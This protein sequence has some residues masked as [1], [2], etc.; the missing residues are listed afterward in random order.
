ME[1]EDSRADD[2]LKETDDIIMK[3]MEEVK[4]GN[5]KET[6]GEPMPSKNGEEKEWDRLWALQLCLHDHIGD[7]TEYAIRADALKSDT[8]V[9]WAKKSLEKIEDIILRYREGRP[10]VFQEAKTWE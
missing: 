3:C 4:M 6:K 5:K 2:Y 1:Y 7:L 8:Y 10:Q 9:S